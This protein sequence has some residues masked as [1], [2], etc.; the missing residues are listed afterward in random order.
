MHRQKRFHYPLANTPPRL[1]RLTLR[2]D[3]QHISASQ[4]HIGESAL[5]PRGL[6]LA[7]VV[8]LQYDTVRFRHHQPIRNCPDPYPPH[9]DHS[10]VPAKRPRCAK[11]RQGIED[12]E[13]ELRFGARKRRID[14]MAAGIETLRVLTS[15]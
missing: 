5:P 6:L 4:R 14:V 13:D 11:P 2:V 3:D 15:K 12:V 1:H 7:D 10:V 9:E 8:A